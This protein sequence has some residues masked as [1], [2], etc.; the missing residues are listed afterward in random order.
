MTSPFES[1]HY[2]P[3]QHALIDALPLSGCRT[4]VYR[5][6]T[7]TYGDEALKLAAM[8]PLLD[9][10]PTP[11]G[12]KSATMLAGPPGSGKTYCGP[13]SDR[14]ED[15]TL[16]GLVEISY[17]EGGALFDLPEYTG[18]L[19]QVEPRYTFPDVPVPVESLEERRHL[20][21]A[22]RSLSCYI[23]DMSLKQ[24]LAGHHS[25]YIDTAASSP[26]SIS[27][28]DTLRK[29]DYGQIEVLAYIAPY[30][31]SRE[32]VETRPR[33]LSMVDFNEKR[34]GF[35]ENFP[36]LVEAADR[37]ILHYNPNNF[38]EPALAA[39]FNAGAMNYIGTDPMR[40]LSRM[41]KDDTNSHHVP[42]RY[43]GRLEKATHG[44]LDFLKKT[45]PA[46]P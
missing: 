30:A 42:E 22:F 43:A 9:V 35:L 45:A 3:E 40:R 39:V 2:T 6:K 25:L 10:S 14:L 44:F 34:I 11:A 41:L 27:L 28:I 20:W 15:A 7:I 8:L 13:T 23:R 46:Q 32:R 19:K 31:T 36:K 16:S 38:N 29:L 12:D 5:G 18:A 26:D 33:P 1:K 21:E 24:A 17:D 37:V 4:A